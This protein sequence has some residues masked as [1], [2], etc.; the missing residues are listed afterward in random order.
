M[1]NQKEAVF[2]AVK[3]VL[4]ESGIG[5][6]GDVGQYMTKDRRASVNAILF[7]GFRKGEIS[8]DREFTDQELKSYVS[9]LQSNWLRKDS[10]LNGGVQYV[11]KN[12]GSRM[13]SGDAQLKALKSLIKIKDDP[14]EV[15]EIQ[16]FIDKRESELRTERSKSVTI[17]VDDLPPE[18]RAKYGV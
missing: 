3:S 1:M 18:L 13:G 4:A 15:A 5:I 7:A 11:P 2:A 10:R 14:S 8:L 16:R 12:P 6:E 9:G 17:N